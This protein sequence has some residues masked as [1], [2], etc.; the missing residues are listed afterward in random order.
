MT[1]PGSSSTK[2]PERGPTA[3]AS[4]SEPLTNAANDSTSSGSRT[5]SRRSSCKRA[6][7]PEPVAT[8]KMRFFSMR[9]FATKSL[10][11]AAGSLAERSIVSDVSIPVS[12]AFREMRPKGAIASKKLSALSKSFSGGKAGRCASCERN[13]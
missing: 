2:P 12:G 5:P 6:A 3:M 11:L 4:G 7:R 13:L 10:S 8:I 1:K 9:H